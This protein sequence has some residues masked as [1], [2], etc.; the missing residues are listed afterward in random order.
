MLWNQA[1]NAQFIFHLIL[2][3]ALFKIVLIIEG[4]WFWEFSMGR[5]EH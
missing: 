4:I 5:G 2:S 1:L 3:L